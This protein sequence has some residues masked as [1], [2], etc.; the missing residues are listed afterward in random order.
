MSFTSENYATAAIFVFAL[1]ILAWGFYR[2]RAYGQLGRL[3]WLQ[4]AMLM[5]PWL[6]FFGAFTLDISINLVVVL[7]L[8][9]VSTGLYIWL[10]SRLRAAAQ[11]PQMAGLMADRLNRYRSNADATTANPEAIDLPAIPHIASDDLEKI[12]GIF[13][14]DTFFATEAIPYQR[15][16]MFK[17]NLRSEPAQAHQRLQAKLQNLMAASDQRSLRESYQVYLLAGPDDRPVVMVM[18]KAEDALAMSWPQ[19][20]L[21]AVLLVATLASSLEVAGVFLGFDFYAHLER[22]PEVFPLTAGLWAVLITHE[23]GHWVMAKKLQVKLSWPSFLPTAQIGSFGAITRL[24]SV[25]S[26]RAALFDVAVA[27]PIAGGIVALGI[28]LV[29]LGLSRSGVG[30]EI[31]TQFFQGSLLVGTLAKG[32][33]GGEVHKTFVHISPLVVIGWLGLVITALNLMPAGQLDGGRMV[34]AIYGR[35]LARRSTIATLIILA[36]VALINPANSVVLY[37]AILIGIL[38]V[39]QEQPCLDE[40][41]EPSDTRAALGLVLL[42]L[43]ITILLPFNPDLAG[44]FGIGG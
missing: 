1:G 20:I 7:L 23:L 39:R 42:F 8:L 37:W 41:T 9:V 30:L 14:I 10:G 21:A 35:K 27:G 36:I 31:P 2:N 5:L 32:V 11:D 33:L 16:A 44:R 17:G 22:W 25:L 12:R 4:S 6:V 13:S 29:G 34:Q 3:A 24:A 40:L 28:L 18:P 38:Q 19:K 26:S 15:G 43:A